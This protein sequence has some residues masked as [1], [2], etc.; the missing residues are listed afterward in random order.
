MNEIVRETL[1][2]LVANYLL[3]LFILGLVVSLSEI[4]TATNPVGTAFVI[5]RLLKWHVF[6]VMGVGYFVNFIFHGFF[7]R[8]SAAFIGWAD[9]PFQF[10]VATASLGFSLVGF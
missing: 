5:D 7:G 1:H 6:F 9:S 4:A 10:E 8:M 3:T 2:F